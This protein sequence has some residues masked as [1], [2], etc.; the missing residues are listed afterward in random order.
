ML[1]L[2][3]SVLQK[4]SSIQ[5]MIF[6]EKKGK[7][8]DFHIFSHLEQRAARHRVHRLQRVHAPDPQPEELPPHRGRVP[9]HQ[10]APVSA[11]L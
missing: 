6:I 11:R 2:F 8:L 1:R 10:C 4:T 5:L 9:V 7:K 3:Q